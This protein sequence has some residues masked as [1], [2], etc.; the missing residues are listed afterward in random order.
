MV[1]AKFS[2]NIIT[3]WMGGWMGGGK[4]DG[5]KKGA[6]S[7]AGQ[8]RAEQGKIWDQPTN[9]PL[10][11]IGDCVAG[12]CEVQARLGPREER[13]ERAQVHSRQIRPRAVSQSVSHP[14][15]H[16]LVT[17]SCHSSI[18][19]AQPGF[20]LNNLSPS[21]PQPCSLPFFLNAT[22]K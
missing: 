14:G 15:P 22:L 8:S 18:A 3:R 7:R 1:N 13:G 6:R 16:G 12:G 17:A 11:W 9:Q 2:V 20:F 4:G 10:G 19:S 5:Q 21:A